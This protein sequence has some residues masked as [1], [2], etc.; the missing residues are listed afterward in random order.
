M[1]RLLHGILAAGLCLAGLAAA[2]PPTRADWRSLSGPLPS[3]AHLLNVTISPDSRYAAYVSD[4]ETPQMFELYVVSL[5]GGTPRKLN[6][7]LPTEGDV[8]AS[9]TVA[10]TSIATQGNRPSYAIQFTPDSQHVVYIADQDVDNRNEL[11]RVPI[12]GGPAKKLNGALVDGG[13]VVDFLLHPDDQS[14]VYRADQETNDDL[15]LYSRA[16]DFGPFKRNGTLTDDGDVAHYQIDPLGNRV[17]YSADQD[18]NGTYELY[19]ASI[20]G[21]GTPLKLNPPI[22]LTG[23]GDRGLYDEWA[24]SPSAPS[25]VFNARQAVSP[26][27][28]LYRRGT[29]GGLL[30]MLGFNLPDTQRLVNF[31]ISPTGERVVFNV[32]TNAGT[33]KAQMGTLY[34]TPIGGGVPIALTEPADDLYG[35]STFDFTPNGERVVYKH[36]NNV[37][38]SG[39]LESST[40]N[41]GVRATIFPNTNTDNPLHRY[42]LSHDSEWVIVERANLDNHWLTAYP[43][44]GGNG[45]SYGLG[46]EAASIPDSN[47]VVFVRN[48]DT[49]GNYGLWSTQIFGG[50]ERDL[51]GLQGNGEIDSFD[52]SPDGKWIVYLVKGDNSLEL[53]VSDGSAAQP[54]APSSPPVSPP[55]SPSPSAQPTSP[56]PSAQPGL[57]RTLLPLAQ[58]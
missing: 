54:P 42:Y 47:R 5:S 24:I 11:Y 45:V 14:L 36:R 56:S 27:G 22:V 33:T 55:A 30:T 10:V 4:A 52:V 3:Y 26:A 9:K 58:R 13:N 44:G 40:V 17:V 8:Q 35:V 50:D 51:S 29:S 53:R 28:Q 46:T 25:V 18:I 16:G 2:A 37:T 23:D 12:K 39:K 21:G 38:V 20:V 6:P 41:G 49:N 34:S 43:T 1:R 31:R 32:G 15:E 7:P 57:H 48:A 19:S